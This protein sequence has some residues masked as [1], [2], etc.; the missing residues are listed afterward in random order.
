[1]STELELKFLL[2]GTELVQLQ[3]ILPQVGQIVHS[4]QHS[5]LNAYFDTGDNWFRRHDMGLRTRQKQGQFEQTIKL[6]GQQHGA[7][8]MRPE[9]NVACAGV[10]PDLAAFPAEIWPPASDIATLQ[11]QLTELFRTD[12][13]RQSWLLRLA[14]NTEIEVA[15][16]QGEIIAAGKRQPI[17]ELE[18]ELLSGQ[19]EQLF[20]LAGNLVTELPLRTGWQS[21]AA[22]GYAL[23]AQQSLKLPDTAGVTLLAQ[24][25]ATQQAEACYEAGNNAAL[26]VAGNA[27]Q[28][29]ARSVA[30]IPQLG[31]WQ[32][33]SATLA[34]TVLLDGTAF[35]SL[36]YQ[37]LLLAVSAY[38]YQ[39]P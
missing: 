30:T 2:P 24:I 20:T 4:A 6:A 21:K 12:F 9:Y 32:T 31:A 8:Q 27:L 15:Y 39:N 34:H 19:A 22:R 26:A 18:L 10:V 16:D 7:M 37:Q 13:I 11:L 23:R 35:A 5:L 28:A 25:R 17:A 3:K 36:E 1:M 14:D 29:L 38:L 33:T